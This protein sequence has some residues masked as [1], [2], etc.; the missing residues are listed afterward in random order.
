M[1]RFKINKIEIAMHFSFFAVVALLGLIQETSY[2][3]LALIACLLHESGHILLMCLFSVPP[4]KITFYGAGIK[5]TPDNRKIT[6][7]IQDFFILIGGSATNITL[8]G[9]IYSTTKSSFNFSLFA[10]F[11]LIIGLFNLLPF[12]HFDGGKIIDLFL[13]T[14]K[15]EKS[16]AVRKIMR[17][18]S[19]ILLV[20]LGLVLLLQGSTNISLY[21]TITFIIFSELIL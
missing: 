21:F 10:V 2:M 8:F 12:K 13:V 5:I 20:G 16:I 11:N 17:Y 3:L 19:V 14:R 6:S 1:L 15:P 9:I 18:I 7:I 4:K